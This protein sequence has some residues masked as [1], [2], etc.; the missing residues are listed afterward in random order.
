MRNR[1]FGWVV[2]ICLVVAISGPVRAH[3]DHGDRVFVPQ[4][5]PVLHLDVSADTAQRDW[6]TA[7]GFDIAGY[8]LPGNRVLVVTD[9]RGAEALRQAGFEFVEQAR[10][11]ERLSLT[12]V[13]ALD[14]DDPLPDTDYTDPDELEVYLD[15]LV[16][17]HPNL[18]R[19][20]ALGTT[21]DG[22]TIWG[23]LISDNP[24]VDED[25]LSVLFNAAHHAR[26]VMSVEVMLDTID[27]LTDNYG[28]DADVT[29]WV[30]TLQIWCVPMV[31]PDGV[32]VVHEEDFN[33]RKNTRDNDNSGTLNNQDGVDLNRNYEWGWGDQCNGSSS[34]F[35]SGIYRGPFEG[36][37]PETMAMLD[38]GRRIRPVFDVEYH[39][40][41][42]DVF[43][44]TS[45][46]PDLFSPKLTTIAGPDQNI[47][48]IIAEEYAGEIIRADGVVG[49]DPAP[50][51]SRVDGTGRDQQYHENG[52]IAFVTELNSSGEGGFRPDYQV[53][54]QPTVEGQRPG[55]QWL[56]DRVHGAAVGGHV[57]NAVTGLPVE[58]DVDLD[59]MLLPD[60]K[61]LTSRPDTGRFHI[62]V[63]PG[64]YTLRVS[65]PGY[66]DATVPLSVT[67]TFQPLQVALTPTGSGLLV[68]EDFENPARVADWV[69]G[70]PADTATAG[71]WEWGEPQGTHQGQVQ[72]NLTRISPKLDRT[73]GRGI[74]AFVTGNPPAATP[75][76]DDVDNGTTTLISP[77]Y[78]L[79][80]SYGV[81][82]SWQR[83]FFRTQDPTDQLVAEVSDDGGASWQTL[84]TVADTTAT[85]DADPA[86]VP[87]P[88][89]RLDDLIAPGPDVRF[90]FRALDASIDT[91]VEAAIDDL[92]VRGFD[93][94]VQGDVAGLTLDGSATTQLS[95]E[96]VP[97][98]PDAVFDVVRG[99]L[100]ALGEG[101]LGALTCVESNSA[102]RAASDAALPTAGQ[103]FFYLVRF[104]S[105]FSTGG[106]GS[107][108]GG[109][110]R[111]G[112]G[113]CP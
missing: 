81:E 95:W 53:W 27:Y 107:S 68:H 70:D 71:V 45:C 9:L 65:A 100:S 50:F 22:A 66:L 42:E 59:Q 60:G 29:R 57:T 98:A 38:L 21:H 47:S 79:S 64:S 102:D 55:W 28:S 76:Q 39:S 73:P 35:T 109:T 2:F 108:S 96:E 1:W 19:R 36:S 10:Y 26:E 90:R 41:G 16:L 63:V 99:D 7:H 34:S 82:V 14:T 48:R 46:D 85:P 86:W 30:D 97:G 5:G 93:L 32:R 40:F 101:S 62:I 89:V 105:G 83:W 88:A 110:A 11:A 104:R 25:E 37:E 6:L 54:R 18:V 13:E 113:G 8:D 52:A 75:D 33:W 43:Y 44:A 61:R 72:S 74:H 58:A 92:I 51:G 91:V 87:S 4:E 69:I 84:E 78:D 15:Q 20:E 12:E 56:L 103:G 24:G 67:D 3:G 17:D 77:A 31:N 94:A 106:Y 112:S 80:G 23:V 111:S 49:Y